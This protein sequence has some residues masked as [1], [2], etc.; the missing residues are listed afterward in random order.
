M[1]L[2]ALLALLACAACATARPPVAAAPPDKA[3]PTVAAT[4]APPPPPVTPVTPPS[5]AATATP[6]PAV[7]VPEPRIALVL[8]GGAARGFAHI[9]VIRVLEQEHIPVNLIVGTSVGSLIA[10]LYAAEGDS[11]DL[12]WTAFQLTQDDIFDFRL[13]NTVVG[14]GYAK[15]DRLEAWVKSKLKDDRIEKLKIPF[16]A[17]ATDLNW[18]KRVVLDKG[19][20][21]RAVRA[22]SAIPGVFEPV[23]HVGKILV[24]GGVIDNIP[25]DVAREKGADLVIAVDISENVGNTNITNALDVVLQSTNIMFAENVAH[26]RGGADV[27]VEP[28]VGGVAMLD[29]SQKK[30]CMQAGME[31]AR[32]M[33]P[34][35]RAAVEEWKRKKAAALAPRT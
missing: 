4:P 16:A 7:N 11:F 21:S 15:G 12:E 9:G 18:G 20:V 1:R 23:Q 13:M 2:P 29:F 22:S 28:K 17:V 26:L 32:K 10:A 31:A 3:P 5:T 6:A 27:L 35:I 14:M 24:D 30:L 34:K 33:M 25:I 8:G 19:P